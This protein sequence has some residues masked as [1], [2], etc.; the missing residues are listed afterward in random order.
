MLKSM[1]NNFVKRLRK[2]NGVHGRRF[3]KLNLFV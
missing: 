1:Q 2:Q 3:S